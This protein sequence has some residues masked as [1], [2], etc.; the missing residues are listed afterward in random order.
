MYISEPARIIGKMPT[1]SR[2]LA[3]PIIIQSWW[4]KGFRRA[5]DFWLILYGRTSPVEIHLQK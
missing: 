1:T 2:A 4:A 5:K 3:V